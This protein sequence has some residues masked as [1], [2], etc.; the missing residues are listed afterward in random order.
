MEY[1]AI[2]AAAASLIGSL[3][4]AGMTLEAQNVRQRIADQFGPDILPELDRVTAQTIDKTA[5]GDIK[6]DPQLRDKQMQAINSLY[7]TYQQGGNTP[8]DV[9]ALQLANDTVNRNAS[10]QQ[11]A[12]QN[13]MAQRGAGNSPL[14]YSLAQSAAQDRLSTLGGM[15]RQNQVDA[16]AR[17]LQALMSG[18]SLAGDV[19]NTDYQHS[20]NLASAQDALN[21]FNASAKERAANANNQLELAGFDANMQRL[22]AQANALNG[23]AAGYQNIG[24]MAANTGAGVGQ[25]ALTWGTMKK[26]DEEK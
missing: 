18:A 5:F 23:V 13:S 15:A 1:A 22:G 19:R 26:K 8:A 21:Q 6:E 16:R 20:A 10:G 11:L 9:A 7:D 4:N 12:L 14:A 17:A 25:A 3:V 2:A 24:Q